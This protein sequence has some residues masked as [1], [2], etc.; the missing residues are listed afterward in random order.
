MKTD[1]NENEEFKKQTND[2]R[3]FKKDLSNLIAG[4]NMVKEGSKNQRIPFQVQN[5][6]LCKQWNE[7]SGIQAKIMFLKKKLEFESSVYENL[8]QICLSISIDEENLHILQNGSFLKDEDLI[9]MEKSL[10]L[11][12]DFS[13]GKYDINIITEISSEIANVI[14]KFLKRFMIFLS[15]IFIESESRSELKVHSAFYSRIKKY[16]FIYKASRSNAEYYN[17][18]C[19]AYVRKSIDLYNKEFQSHLDRIS[20]L[21]NDNKGLEIAIETIVKS[22]ACLLESEEDFMAL[23]GM[24]SDPKEI[25]TDVDSMI[26]NFFD[27]FYKQ[28][29]YCVLASISQFMDDEAVVKIGSLG[30]AL[31]KKCISLNEIFLHQQRSSN[32]SF[33]LVELINSL[34]SRNLNEQLTARLINLAIEKAVNPKLNKS[35]AEGIK[36]IQIMHCFLDLDDLPKVISAMKKKLTGQI[37]ATVFSS[38]EIKS[39]ISNVFGYLNKD[40]NG[41]SETKEFLKS[42]IL[43]NCDETNRSEAIRILSKF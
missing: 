23:M 38:K 31:N 43:E 28:S 32:L 7:F 3:A 34:K 18:L 21:V 26:I 35:L 5:V 25:F 30:A 27:M 8:K 20:G 39:E 22:Y 10:N 15:K 24:N 4:V 2:L 40:R 33:D 42:A 17:I 41:L 16:K 13:E 6:T 19:K 37:I 12:A 11:L 14:V 1:E 9:K 36:N 29:S